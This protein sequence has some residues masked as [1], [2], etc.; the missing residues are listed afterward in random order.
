MDDSDA[1]LWRRFARDVRPLR[2]R[3]PPPV[4][5][6]QAP[7]PP[8]LPAPPA[9]AARPAAAAPPSSS[10]PVP[11]SAGELSVGGAPGLDQRTFQRLKR[12]LIAPEAEIDLHR[13]TQDQAHAALYR[14]VVASQAA[15]RRCVLVI[16]GKG[17]GSAG[18]VGVLKTSVPRWLN[19]PALRV[20]V[21]ALAYATAAWGGDGALFV[22]LRRKRD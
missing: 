15:G 4:Q 9:A 18:A 13:L 16:T 21:L 20:R 12:G 22:L 10:T 17:Y 5:P 3:P 6:P 8:P 2:H 19:E 1:E 14:F 7:P 11:P